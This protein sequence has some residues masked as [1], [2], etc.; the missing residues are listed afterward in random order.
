MDPQLNKKV[1]ECGVK[2]VPHRMRVRIARRRNDEENAKE[3]LYSHV[4]AVNIPTVK[5]LHTAVVEDQPE[6]EQ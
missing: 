1:W 4:Y 5:G 6:Q 2:G 3:K